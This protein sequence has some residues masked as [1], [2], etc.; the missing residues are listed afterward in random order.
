MRWVPTREFPKQQDKFGNPD[1][2]LYLRIVHLSLGVY[3]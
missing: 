1:A 3:W 2:V